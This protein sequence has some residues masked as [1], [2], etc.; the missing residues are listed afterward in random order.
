MG[1]AHSRE[2]EAAQSHV[3]RLTSEL[4]RMTSEQQSSQH[5][6]SQVA[7]QAARAASLESELHEAKQALES[8]ATL[9]GELT[10]SQEEAAARQQQLREMQAELRASK[11]ELERVVGELKFSQ[12]EKQRAA[13]QDAKEEARHS[14]Q[15]VSDANAT[16][17][18]TLALSAHPVYGE[19]L[20]DYGHKRLYRG[21]PLTLW[22]GTV[23]W[24]SQ[25]AFRRERA[26][27]IAAA[28]WRSS[29]RGWPGSITVV[30]LG[31]AEPGVLI[32]G[33]HRLGAAFA[34]EQ[35]GHLKEELQSIFVE[36]YP[37]MPDKEVKE[38]FTEINK[39]EPVTLIDLPDVGAEPKDNEIITNVAQLLS[40]RYPNMFKPSHN[41]RPPHVNVDVL[42]NKIFQANIIR[43]KGIKSS[44]EL[45]AWLEARNAS[46]RAVAEALAAGKVE[47]VAPN[48]AV[49]ESALTKARKEDF[50]LGL[51]WDW[52]HE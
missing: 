38:L 18:Q 17:T 30:S 34:L 23:V 47:D 32:D 29:V 24:E 28:K 2:L 10:R 40:T 8:K 7:K 11:A 42:R 22:T 12:L 19:L 15:L 41:C 37:P 14:A 36:V 4:R 49:R 25:R 46:Q 16:L 1:G 43:D 13:S 48:M 27:V 31:E 26:K 20:A 9:H 52:L 21:H 35:Q 6:L 33:Q 39:A 50:Y 3:K 44:E 51:G 45:L 5:R